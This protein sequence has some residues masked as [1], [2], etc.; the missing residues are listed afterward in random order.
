[1]THATKRAAIGAL[2]LS[3]A[4]PA[5]AVPPLPQDNPNSFITVWTPTLPG[6]AYGFFTETTRIASSPLP[7]HDFTVAAQLVAKNGPGVHQ[8]AFGVASEAWAQPGSRSIL[9][10]LESAVIN[11]EP[12]NTYPKIANNAVMK[13]R[14]DGAPNPGAPLNANSIAYW[15]TAQPGTGFERGLVFDSSSIVS[16]VCRPVAIDL[17]DL[18]DDVIGNIDLIRIRKDVALRYDPA[19]KSLV[20]H[21]GP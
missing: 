19:T 14:A 9:V 18:P 20:L 16:T 4:T 7:L 1:M 21:V 8:W 13:N 5:L 10:G 2:C 3:L 12:T 15:I 11:E 6:N 17:S